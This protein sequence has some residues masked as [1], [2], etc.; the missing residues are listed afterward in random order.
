MADLLLDTFTDTNGTAIASHT[1][2]TGSAPGASAGGAQIQSNA[3]KFTSPLTA[4]YN[5][6]RYTPASGGNI[7]LSVKLT[8]PASGNVYVEVWFNYT[9]MNNRW[10]VAITQKEVSLYRVVSSVSTLMSSRSMSLRKAAT[11]QVF[12]QAV[13]DTITIK[14]SG[15]YA[16]S[17]FEISCTVASRALKTVTGLGL[18]TYTDAS[19]LYD[20]GTT[21]D[22]LR[23]TD[24]FVDISD[25][26]PA[27]I[28]LLRDTFTGTNGTAISG[29][30]PDVGSSP[31]ALT[32]TWQIQSNQ[33]KC[34]TP[35]VADYNI[36]RYSPGGDGNTYMS[37]KVTTPAS[38]N[39]YLEIW[40]NYQDAD[41]FWYVG[42]SKDS[43]TVN[44]VQQ[45]AGAFTTRDTQ[46]ITLA[47]STT[48][49]VIIRAVDDTITVNFS[50][51]SSPSPF[52]LDWTAANRPL[53]TATGIAL[54]TYTDGSGLYDQGST[55][56]D[57]QY[58]NVDPRMASYVDTALGAD[59]PTGYDPSTF[60][61]SI[62]GT[63]VGY[64]TLAN[65]IAAAPV[66][67]YV[68]CR[69][70]QTHTTGITVTRSVHIR[71]FGTG[72]AVLDS[73][74]AYA[75]GAGE[76]GIYFSGN[77]ESSVIGVRGNIQMI[78]TFSEGV[79]TT[80][81]HNSVTLKVFTGGTVTVRGVQFD[82]TAHT[83]I[84]NHFSV[85][86]DSVIEQCRFTDGGFDGLDH[87]IYDA[88]GGFTI[89][90]N[91]FVGITGYGVHVYSDVPVRTRII[92]NAFR[93]CGNTSGIVGGGPLVDGTCGHVIRHNTVV[94][95]GTGAAGVGGITLWGGSNN[96]DIQN[97]YVQCPGANSDIYIQS[98]GTT[99][100]TE[101]FNRKSTVGGPGAGTYSSGTDVTTAD[102]F[103]TTPD[104]LTDMRR[105]G[106]L[107]DGTDL[108]ADSD[109]LLDPNDDWPTPKAVNGTPPIGAF[110]LS[111]SYTQ[112]E[113]LA[114][115]LNRGLGS[116]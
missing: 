86:L 28:A 76:H 103:D 18:S 88:E 62:S 92:A 52:Q 14:F 40:F 38:G 81:P 83:A 42:I 84:K 85:P 56:D 44:L 70:G 80:V 104:Q 4:D 107:T 96:T 1:P 58:T 15:G 31:T 17:P 82:G 113:R 73:R 13:G 33:L 2:N 98:A 36:V 54:T 19:G 60:A 115:G 95:C 75:P 72:T 30:S 105:T 43:N 53:K 16:P 10:F 110:A 94:D 24:G 109:L 3:L 71:Q 55:Y 93:Q 61:A 27:T 8:T 39:Y 97:N 26:T 50:G 111:G 66:G 20:Q 106:G 100:I 21:F 22:D 91:E 11:Y 59:A 57:L 74:P 49:T 41:N 32:N 78:G 63:G 77:G 45:V 37:V 6:V 51:G 9:D 79:N 29:R 101:G 108:G 116:L 25:L 48:Y 68:Y 7:Y 69:G 65:A 35:L 67:A 64:T 47:T 99:D 23:V 34:T 114:R 89:R 102:L 87:H 5:Y 12:L 46:A 112:C 90:H